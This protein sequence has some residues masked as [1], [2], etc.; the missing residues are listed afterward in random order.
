MYLWS[1]IDCDVREGLARRREHATTRADLNRKLSG[2][3]RQPRVPL[4]EP[5]GRVAG[6][7]GEHAH[8][9][10]VT[11][12]VGDA[13]ELAVPIDEAP[14]DV[15]WRSHDRRRK[16]VGIRAAE[17]GRHAS[18][19]SDLDLRQSA[20]FALQLINQRRCRGAGWRLRRTSSPRDGQ[21]GD[22]DQYADREHPP[23]GSR[24]LAWLDGAG[25][26]LRHPSEDYAR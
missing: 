17:E 11:R 8:L 6:L 9:G 4:L 16:W 2:E 15:R 1:D 10:Q 18:R 21:G 24:G 23:L 14:G 12:R 26:G 7:R 20:R 22:K 25:S 13:E 5:D 19:R 3:H